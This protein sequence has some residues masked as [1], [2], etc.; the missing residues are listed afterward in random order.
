MVF[1]P[2]SLFSAPEGVHIAKSFENSLQIVDSLKIAKQVDEVFVIGGA[3]LYK[4]IVLNYTNFTSEYF[5]T[6]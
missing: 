1:F 3:G 4:V 5:N 2:N 6:S